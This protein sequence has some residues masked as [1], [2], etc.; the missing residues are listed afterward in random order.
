MSIYCEIKNEFGTETYIL[1]NLSKKKKSLCA[2]IRAT[3]LGLYIETVKYVGTG[4]EDRIWTLCDLK[5]VENKM[6]VLCVAGNANRKD[7][8]VFDV[9]SKCVL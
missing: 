2:Q 6:L 9:L 1:Y 5:N 8:L 3:I 7:C 4:E